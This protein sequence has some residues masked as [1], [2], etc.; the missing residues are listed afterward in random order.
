MLSWT[1]GLDSGVDRV[2]GIHWQ[3]VVEEVAS[4]NRDDKVPGGHD[5]KRVEGHL[6]H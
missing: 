6:W 1:N 3:D 2:L 5:H 4:W